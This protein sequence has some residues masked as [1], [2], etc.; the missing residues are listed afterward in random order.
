MEQQTLKGTEGKI[1][2]AMIDELLAIKGQEFPAKDQYNTEASRDNIRHYAE[3]LG[4][5]N[6]LWSDAE[7]ARKTRYGGIIAPP[8]FLDSCTGR[9]SRMG[10]PG[11]HAFYCAA[12]WYFYK[13]VRVGDAISVG[14]G[15]NDLIEKESKFSRRSF[16]QSH[17]VNYRNQNNEI[18]ATDIQSYIRS[19][20][21]TAVDQG[22]YKDVK[23]YE[24]TEDEL[25]RIWEAIDNED[26]RGANPRYWEDVQVG[27]EL[28]V[29]VKGPL[30][31]S[32]VIGFK[33]G[34]G[35][36][37]VHHIRANENRFRM[38]KRHP[39]IP[40]RDTLNLPDV[41]EAVH[42]ADETS[43]AIGFPAWYDYG[44]QRVGWAAQLVTNWIG[45]D[46]WL[47]EFVAE[48][49]RPN[50]HGDTQWYK[51]TVTKKW[52]EKEENLVEC[53]IWAE[54]Q[55]GEITAPGSAIVSLPSRS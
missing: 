6:P 32:D 3:G 55:R 48:V 4:D 23:K 35:S 17:F 24:Y 11:I 1:T 42:M 39:G 8:T 5:L 29:V 27:A 28:P 25:Q 19:E 12:H 15:V 54:N 7:Y 52:Q 14:G 50:I 30:V 46:G 37:M 38:I 22:K 2:Q 26:I 36:H 31:L 43:T 51:G 10:F 53:K 40:L 18:V 16:L 21:S 9:V 44:Y 34:W 13:P 49:R 33:M 20:R 47:K 41:P 45:D